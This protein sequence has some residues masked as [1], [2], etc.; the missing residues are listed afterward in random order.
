MD[1]LEKSMDIL[2]KD[3]GARGIDGY[4]DLASLWAVQYVALTG[5]AFMTRG[6]RKKR[7]Q[8]ETRESLGDV[9]EIVVAEAVSDD[10]LWEA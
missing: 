7:H 9:E 10:P 1:K 6:G 3:G 8:G 4:D 5:H 2:M